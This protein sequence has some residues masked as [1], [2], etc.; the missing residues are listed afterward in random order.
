[1]DKNLLERFNNVCLEQGVDPK[2][3]EDILT[4]IK[5]KKRFGLV[6]EEHP[7]LIEEQLKYNNPLF[8]ELKDRRI[9]K[10]Y[11]LSNNMLIEGDNL[12]AL[13]ALQNID[14]KVDVIYI[15]PPY[16]TG[17]EFVYND[18]IVDK[19]DSFRHSKWLSFMEKRLKVARELLNDDGVIFVSI[20]DNEQAHLKML[21]DDVFGSENFVSNVIYDGSLKNNT[22]FISNG[23]DYMLIYVKNKELLIDQDVKWREEKQGLDLLLEFIESLNN[24]IDLSNNKEMELKKFLKDNKSLLGKGLMNYNKIEHHNGKY[25]IFRSG[26]ISAPGGNGQTYDIYHPVTKK[27]V[28]KPKG[29]WRYS[30]MTMQN[31]LNN[32]EILFGK[33]ETTVPQFKRILSKDENDTQVVRSYFWSERSLANKELESILG[34]KSFDFPK[35]V[36]VLKRWIQ[37]VTNN[38]KNAK[39]LDFFAGSGTTGHAVIELNKEDGGKREF[40]LC[41]NNENNI[42]EDVTYERLKRVINGYTTPKGKDIEGLPANLMYMKIEQSEKSNND[43]IFDTTPGELLKQHVLNSL[44]VKFHLHTEIPVVDGLLYSLKNGSTVYY[45]YFNDLMDIE[46]LNKLELDSNMKHVMVTDETLFKEYEF[47]KR[48]METLAFNDFV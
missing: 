43:V 33:D 19:E 15:D 35:H 37:L 34:K 8:T 11:G 21:M 41:T 13:L 7:E 16:N 45:V 9:D 25:R 1:M 28:K 44:K 36:D 40:I 47:K 5:N 14:K 18:K 26:D 6:Y 4:E 10:G 30:Y 12:E 24:S 27:S 22:R 23:H 39:V 38:N 3:F 42:C 29:G 32:N 48:G 2:A 20:D 17:N 31:K 46:A